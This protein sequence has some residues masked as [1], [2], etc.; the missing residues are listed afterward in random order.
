MATASCNA[1]TCIKREAICRK[2]TIAIA[3]RTS[4]NRVRERLVARGTLGQRG[5][6]ERASA[7]HS[8]ATAIK[9]RHLANSHSAN[10]LRAINTPHA[11]PEP[12]ARA[13]PTGRDKLQSVIIITGCKSNVRYGICT[14]ATSGPDGGVAWGVGRV[15]RADEGAARDHQCFH[16]WRHRVWRGLRGAGAG[17]EGGHPRAW[18]VRIQLAGASGQRRRRAPGYAGPLRAP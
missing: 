1:H 10:P 12:T 14:R 8:R 7:R 4:R 6:T 17:A 18:C 13:T 11:V 15:Q 5:K 3:C 16:G 2:Y 9:Q